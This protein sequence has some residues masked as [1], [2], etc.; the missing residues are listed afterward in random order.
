MRKKRV[1]YDV[2]IR[3]ISKRRYSVREY[4]ASKIMQLTLI[5]RLVFLKKNQIF[6]AI[7]CRGGP[8]DQLY[9][10][11]LATWE[12]G[13]DT[14]RDSTVAQLISILLNERLIFIVRKK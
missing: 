13:S 8:S 1:I 3:N 2:F 10:V 6:F 9:F 5:R 14:P 7:T 12:G 4:F 11:L